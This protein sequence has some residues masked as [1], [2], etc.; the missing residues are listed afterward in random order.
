MTAIVLPNVMDKRI[1]SYAAA[2]TYSGMS[3]ASAAAL[4]PVRKAAKR[5]NFGFTD[6]TGVTRKRIGPVRPYKIAT[7][8]RYRT[9]GAYFRAGGIIGATLEYRF[10]RRYSYIEPAIREKRS[11]TEQAFIRQA[12]K[13]VDKAVAIAR[14]IS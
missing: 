13:E 2:L 14:R 7:A 10:G 12:D 9:G 3:N 11:E 1:Q 6:R 4:R 5:K 8:R